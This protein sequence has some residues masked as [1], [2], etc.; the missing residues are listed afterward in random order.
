MPAEYLS[1]TSSVRSIS[2]LPTSATA[3]RTVS[4]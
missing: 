3:R 4:G 1:G 2:G